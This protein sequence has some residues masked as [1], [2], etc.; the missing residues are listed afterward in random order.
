MLL[1]GST[2]FIGR[3]ATPYLRDR[4]E[5]ATPT[6]ADLDLLD[7]AATRRYLK[8]GEFDIIVHLANPTAQNPVDREEELFERSM[9]V[10]ASLAHCNDLYGK[11]LY[12]GSGAEYGK[13][14]SIERIAETDFGRE[15]PRDA[16]G[17]SRYIMNELAEKAGNIHNLRVFGCYGSGDPP[18][19]LMPHIIGRIRANEP[20]ELRQNVRFD[21]L[22][23][24]D[25]APVL[26]HFVENE[27][28]HKAYNL[29]SGE[30]VTIGGIAME[31]RRLMNSNAPIVFEKDGLGLAYTGSNERL[32]AE[33]PQWRPTAIEAGIK[34]MLEN[35]NRQF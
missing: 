28:K 18:Y 4:Y 13:H 12:I 16:Y 30:P 32:R 26:V 27:P 29:C 3:N 34:E 8:R 15:L 14:R 1:L 20:I 10:F 33:A 24:K 11:M 22:Y 31:I 21:F 17:L 23:V 7:S 19:K 6:R 5:I 9:R 2:G 25:I 35:E